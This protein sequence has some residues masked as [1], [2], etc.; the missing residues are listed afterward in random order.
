MKIAML[1][2]VSYLPIIYDLYSDVNL[3]FEYQK[4]AHSSFNTS[5]LLTCA[6]N[7]LSINFKTTCNW[8]REYSELLDETTIK[9][10]FETVYWMTIL[11][12]SISIFIY[13]YEVWC[14]SSPR[15]IKS[16][17]ETLKKNLLVWS[18]DERFSQMILKIV[19]FSL[20]LFFKICWPFV[21]VYQTFR[22]EAA[23]K[24]VME[25]ERYKESDGAWKI[26]KAVEHHIE[27]NAQLIFQFYLLN[28]FFPLLDTWTL[29]EW[30]IR[31]T[32]GI[33]NFFTFNTFPA[34]YIEKA[35][36]KI[37]MTVFF[38]SLSA[39]YQK[40]NKNGLGAYIFIF[41]SIYTQHVGRLLT[42]KILFQMTSQHEELNILS[43][44]IL[45]FLAVTIIK[46]TSHEK[47]ENNL[48]NSRFWLSVL[49]ST[50]VMVQMKDQRAEPERNKKSFYSHAR[51]FTLILAGK[52]FL[53]IV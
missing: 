6:P 30:I 29:K 38:S 39:T 27:S 3:A 15:I 25:K 33:G 43:C 26:I 8:T 35:I 47:S 53:I 50:M 23:D 31:S 24:K 12:I 37:F 9:N 20:I 5:E 40:E 22:Y 11:T 45:H 18:L 41:G 32:K 14:H 4:N 16:W 52:T 44:L 49:S 17:I 34:C 48:R 1:L 46:K 36:G 2:L 51:F 13:I 10:R 7:P 28:S 21:H 19:E 42:I